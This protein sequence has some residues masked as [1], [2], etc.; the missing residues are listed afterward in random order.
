[1]AAGV[2]TKI[3]NISR[4]CL[5]L[6][7]LSCFQFMAIVTK[8]CS[9]FGQRA[10]IRSNLVND[11]KAQQ[12]DPVAL[13]TVW[14]VSF[15]AMARW[16]AAVA[17]GVAE[18]LLPATTSVPSVSGGGRVVAVSTLYSVL[19]TGGPRGASGYRSDRE[20][21]L[22]APRGA[23]ERIKR[24]LE[25]NKRGTR[26]ELLVIPWPDLFCILGQDF[27]QSQWKQLFWQVRV[28]SQNR[29]SN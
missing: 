3:R 20:V 18:R 28:Y 9:S 27:D 17:L 26:E 21:Y 12:L 15:Q 10:H 29:K 2:G 16:A 19:S 13:A 5:H 11:R 22:R 24:I 4:I 7:R 25:R 14:C 8:L 23:L 6:C 1:M